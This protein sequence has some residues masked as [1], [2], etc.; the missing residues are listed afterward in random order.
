VTGVHRIDT[1]SAAV[2]A[3]WS[4]PFAHA[5]TQSI[6]HMTDGSSTFASARSSELKNLGFCRTATLIAAVDC[7]QFWK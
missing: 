4:A 3:G 7:E 2:P 1:A 5:A 6:P